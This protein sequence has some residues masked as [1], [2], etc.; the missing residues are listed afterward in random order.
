MKAFVLLP[1]LLLSSCAVAEL[2]AETGKEDV[3][4]ERPGMLRTR[5]SGATSDS[6]S[7]LSRLQSDV[8]LMLLDQIYCD[9]GVLVLAL[10]RE[11]ALD[12]GIPEEL[13]DKYDREVKAGNDAL[14]DR[15]A[16]QEAGQP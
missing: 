16:T 15:M 9:G 1:V 13:Y 7:V 6:L 12:L 5:S 11:D 2:V 8:E 3:R 10:S 4:Q 14:P